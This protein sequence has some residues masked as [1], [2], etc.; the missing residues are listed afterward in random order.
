LQI[1]QY[2][3]IALDERRLGPDAVSIYDVER[4]RGVLYFVMN[5]LLSGDGPFHKYPRR[6]RE[7]AKDEWLAIQTKH[8]FLRCCQPT[9][10]KLSP[11]FARGFVGCGPVAVSTGV[12]PILR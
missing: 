6:Q 11:G 4:D 12:A 8:S 7:R 5:S 10:R 2:R 9:F 3:A 1:T